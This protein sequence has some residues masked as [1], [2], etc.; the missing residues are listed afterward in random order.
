M[1]THPLDRRTLLARSAAVASLAALMGRTPLSSAVAAQT[2]AA[3]AVAGDDPMQA[4]VA[5]NTA[6]ALDLYHQLRAG[7]SG[8]LI[9]SP[10]SVS[11]ALAMTFAGARGETASQMADVLG[12]SLP[13]DDLHAAFAALTAD[14]TE[15]ANTE[16]SE[17]QGGGESGLR[18]ANS[19]WGEQTFPFSTAFTA[20][21]D[22]AY[23]AG[24]EQTDFVNAPEQ[25]RDDINAWVAEH[26]EDRIQDIVPEGAI[27]AATRLVLANAIWFYGSW[28]DSFDPENTADEP[29]NLSDGTTVDVPFM[30]QRENFA[31][32][33]TDGMQLVELPYTAGGYAMTVIL[34]DEG[35]FDSVEEALDADT[36]QSAINAL[37]WTDVRLWLPKFEFE[38]STSLAQTLQALGMSDALDPDLADF[39]GMVEERAD[40]TETIAIGEV[41]HK[42]FIAIDEEGTEAAAATVVMMPTSAA[43]QD[44]EEPVE[45]RVDRPFLFAIRDTTTGT[46]LF[47]GR[48][49]DPS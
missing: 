36:L 3:S 29:F 23:G 37:S 16:R 32:A 49:T 34:P 42:A 47:L 5:G 46:V 39:S 1:R 11:L 24:L 41:L 9:F 4:L 6:F 15:R 17:A 31:Y 44:E 30:Y 40:T 27:T 20:Q 14:L 22:D 26:T 12:F 8:N 2:P 28:L 7:D 10:Y 33:E 19:L 45:L 38:L 25:A 43:P 35:Q 48:V 18:I 21:L 13:D